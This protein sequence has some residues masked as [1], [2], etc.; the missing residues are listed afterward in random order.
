VAGTLSNTTTGDIRKFEL[1]PEQLSEFE[2]V[3]RL[4]DMMDG[5]Q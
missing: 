3:N 4:W 5:R 1:D 2:I